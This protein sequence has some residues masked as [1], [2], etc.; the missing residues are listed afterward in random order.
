MNA[1]VT[2]SLLVA[3]GLTLYLVITDLMEK[4]KN[5]KGE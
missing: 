2:W 4:E 5:Y 1:F 3:A